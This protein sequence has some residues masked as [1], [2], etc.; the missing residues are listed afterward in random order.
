MLQPGKS[1]MTT[2]QAKKGDDIVM[3]RKDGV[4]MV[5]LH[6]RVTRHSPD[7]FD[8]GYLGSGPSDLALNILLIYVDEPTAWL[9]HNDFKDKF[10]AKIEEAGGVIPAQKIQE[11]LQINNKDLFDGH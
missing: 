1:H 2:G 3:E 4:P 7:G 10:V 8:W 6:Q 11:Y 5:N 9:L